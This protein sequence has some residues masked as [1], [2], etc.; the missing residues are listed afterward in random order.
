MTDIEL[1][2]ILRDIATG[3]R[4][5]VGDYWSRDYCNQAAAEIEALRAERDSFQRVGIAAQAKVDRLAEAGRRVTAAFRA[6]GEASSFTRQ[7]ERTR[8]ECEAAMLSLA[9]ALR[10]HDQE[11]GNG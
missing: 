8:H 7:A 10:D 6:H 5:S 4:N 2:A 3:R 9:D 11:V 1:P